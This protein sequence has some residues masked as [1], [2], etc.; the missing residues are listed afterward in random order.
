MLFTQK[1]SVWYV[2]MHYFLLRYGNKYA[3]YTLKLY[4]LY[5]IQHDMKRK[6][7]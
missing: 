4:M 6:S 5:M 3:T 2:I 1:K 7:C